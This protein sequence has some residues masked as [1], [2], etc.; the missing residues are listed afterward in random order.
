VNRWSRANAV[1]RRRA[2]TLFAPDPNEEYLI[3]QTIL[4]AWPLEGWSPA[5]YGRF[6]RRMQAYAV[7]ALHEA[8]VHSSWAD[9]NRDYDEAVSEFVR[10]ILDPAVSRPFLE[11]MLELERTVRHFGLL[12]SL[13]QTLLKLT[14]PGVPDTYQGTEIWDQSLVD[15]DNRRPVNYRLRRELLRAL[16]SATAAAGADRRPLCHELLDCKEDGRIKLFVHHLALQCR[17][18]HPGL[19]SGGA[20]VPLASAGA[21]ASHL[22]AFARRHRDRWAIVVAPRLWVRLAGTPARP[23]LGNAVWNDTWLELLGIDPAVRW[24]NVFTGEALS[25]I[26]RARGPSMAAAQLLAHFPVALCLSEAPGD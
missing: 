23:P 13:S 12:N 9:R 20:Y 10:L 3:Y 22:F 5:V 19:F 14:S 11:D 18:T 8:K 15:P 4:G 17:R 2:G 24:R 6:V 26:D 7:K 25:A 1:H 21:K 16:R